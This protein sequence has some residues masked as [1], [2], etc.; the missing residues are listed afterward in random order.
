MDLVGMHSALRHDGSSLGRS[1]GRC[2][3]I[4]EGRASIGPPLPPEHRI[5]RVAQI[6]TEVVGPIERIDA[7]HTGYLLAGNGDW[8]PIAQRECA[9]VHQDPARLRR[10]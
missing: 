1:S 2:S 3:P 9:L 8:G 5:P 10:H 6:T 4:L 7:T